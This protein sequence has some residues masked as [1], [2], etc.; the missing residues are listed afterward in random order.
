MRKLIVMALRDEDQDGPAQGQTRLQRLVNA[1]Q[2]VRD[3]IWAGPSYPAQLAMHL[4]GWQLAQKDWVGKAT[5]L[6]VYCIT[7]VTN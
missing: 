3:V 5:V 4:G 1:V 2:A 7:K 6:A